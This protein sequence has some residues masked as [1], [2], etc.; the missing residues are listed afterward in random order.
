MTFQKASKHESQNIRDIILIT[1][2]WS[3]RE[4]KYDNEIEKVMYTQKE[5]KNAELS[6]KRSSSSLKLSTFILKLEKPVFQC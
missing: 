6:A 5:K 2:G 4:N 3:E 1:N